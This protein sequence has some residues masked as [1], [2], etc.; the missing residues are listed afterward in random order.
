MT[1]SPKELSDEWISTVQGFLVE[2]VKVSQKVNI[3]TKDMPEWIKKMT[4]NYLIHTGKLPL[5]PKP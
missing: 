2:Y 1:P 5:P 4:E 3:P